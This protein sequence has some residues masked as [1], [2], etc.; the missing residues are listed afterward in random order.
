MNIIET[1]R[2]RKSCRTFNNDVLTQEHRI[3]IE[4]YI[5]KNNKTI[6]G[7]IIDFKIIQKEDELK[8]MKLDYGIIKGHNTYV[9]GISKST[10]Y[11]RVNYGY[12]M[13]KI[14][15]KA[16]EIG[17]STCWIGIFDNDYFDD[18]SID[19]G[20]EIPSIVILGYPKSKQTNLDKFVRFNLNA[21]KRLPWEKLFFNYHTNT[22]LAFDL[23][24]K[25]SNS[26]E[27]LRLAPSSGNTQPWRIFFDDKINEYHFFK[28]SISKKYEKIGL[29]DI[30]LGI[31][32]SHFELVSLQNNLLG[33]WTKKSKDDINF[34]DDMQYI[35]TWK[36]E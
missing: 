34:L 32:L 28:K 33:R 9:L 1:I 4:N 6:S 8:K 7:E 27:M 3:D 2:Q 14:V 31:A 13:E 12:L 5:S 22:P 11:S 25:Y 24:N 21:S 36:C 23:A 26:L 17:I 35:M 29:H 10:P 30:D 18:I 19:N 20:F 16:T 15:L